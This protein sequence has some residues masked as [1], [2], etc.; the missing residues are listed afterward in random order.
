MEVHAATA[1]QYRDFATYCDDSPCFR[2]WAL[3]VA[4]DA[5]VLAWLERLPVP[6]RQPNLVLAAARYHGVPAP[7]PYDALRT[8]LLDDD[9]RVEHTIRTR[10]TQTNEA[11]RLATLLPAFAGV[12][13]QHPGEPIALVEVGA[14]AGLVLHPDRWGYRWRTADG[15]VVLPAPAGAGELVCDVTGPAPLPGAVPEVAFRAGLDLAPVDVTDPDQAAW[16]RVLVWPEHDDRR[17]VLDRAVEIARVDPPDLRAGDLLTDVPDLVAEA[18]RHGR[19]VLFHTAV[20]AYVEEPGR[21]AF[22]TMMRDLVADGACHWV[23][24]EGRRVLPAVT[25]STTAEP[26]P[27]SFVLGVDGSAVAFTHGH[28]RAL[29]WLV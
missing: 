16:L 22:D 2:D 10:A 17:A 6:K 27:G 28:G 11:G 23:S 19:V 4:D 9:G 13:A 18:G 24:N 14:S 7:G 3:R 29:H 21:V 15:D 26:V 8:A 1:E 20:L 12:A 25:G 5:A